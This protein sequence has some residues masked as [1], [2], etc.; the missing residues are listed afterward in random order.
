MKYERGD[1]LQIMDIVRRS[2]PEDK[3]PYLLHP[4][5]PFSDLGLR[6]KDYQKWLIDF[7]QELLYRAFEPLPIDTMRSRAQ[8][9]FLSKAFNSDRHFGGEGHTRFRHTIV[10]YAIVDE[11]SE[12]LDLP[13]KD[14]N[15][16][17]LGIILHDIAIPAGGDAIKSLDHENLDEEGVWYKTLDRKGFQ[18]LRE[19]AGRGVVSKLHKMINGQNGGVLDQIIDFADKLSYTAVDAEYAG[20]LAYDP[21][22]LF[23]N[24]G[25][26][27]AEYSKFKELLEANI[28]FGRV[29]ESIRKDDATNQIYFTDTERLKAFLKIRAI[30]FRNL[31]LNGENQGRDLFLRLLA[32]PLYS[33]DG[34]SELGPRSL[35]AMS[36]IELTNVVF[37]KQGEGFAQPS[38][39]YDHLRKWKPKSILVETEEAAQRLAKELKKDANIRIIGIKKSKKF[40]PALDFRVFDEEAQKIVTVEAYDP[41]FAQEMNGLACS[42][43]GYYVIY[44]NVSEDSSINRLVK[45][46]IRE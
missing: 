29:Y 42:T 10:A 17:K 26:D 14:R 20:E 30:L 33:S 38:D 21:I 27:M 19:I 36:D 3:A 5:L 24:P 15:L 8:L 22:M 16:L 18:F 35:R 4:F 2:D 44:E 13:E 46:V 39:F 28:D 41:D 37:N 12:I 43:Q 31:Y 9:G 34:V 11:V 40:N 6:V 32:G 23:V 7:E 45:R 25:I 1:L